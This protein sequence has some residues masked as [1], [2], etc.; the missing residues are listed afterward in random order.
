M[1]SYF[2][3]DTVNKSTFIRYTGDLNLFKQNEML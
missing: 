2:N 3:F 1:S